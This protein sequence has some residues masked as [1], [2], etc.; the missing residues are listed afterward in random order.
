MTLSRPIIR[1]ARV[2]AAVLVIGTV[3]AEGRADVSPRGGPSG[4][5]QVLDSTHIAIAD[6]SGNPTYRVPDRVLHSAGARVAVP[7]LPGLTLS[8][9]IRNLLD[10]RTA[11][12]PNAIGGTDRYPIGDLFDYPIPG[13]RL[14]L[15]ARWVFPELKASASVRA[16]Q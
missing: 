3:G 8:L 15:S 9:D 5:V 16:P 4:F 11:E 10:L 13:R 7:S 6:L 2:L 12:Y 14:L 1:L